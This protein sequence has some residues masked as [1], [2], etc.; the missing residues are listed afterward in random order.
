MK[1]LHFGLAVE[2]NGRLLET[3]SPYRSGNR[4]TLLDVDFDPLLAKP[5]TLKALNARLSAAAGDDAKTAAALA[6]FPGMKIN[7]KPEVLI[8]FS[9]K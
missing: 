3:T 6:E 8:E 9:G 4:V 5:E 1:G 7:T 2:V